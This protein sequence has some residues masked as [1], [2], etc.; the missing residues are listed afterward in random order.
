MISVVP[1]FSNLLGWL[2]YS[3]NL[4]SNGSALLS[5]QKELDDTITRL[6]VSSLYRSVNGWYMLEVT[7]KGASELSFEIIARSKKDSKIEQCFH[8]SCKGSRMTKRIAFFPGDHSL[9]VK[10]LDLHQF[11]Q[12]CDLSLVKLTKS[13]A[14]TR[15][16]SKVS[17]PSHIGLSD[18]YGV[19]GAS[20]ESY[21]GQNEYEIWKRLTEPKLWVPLVDQSS[22]ERT[23][24]VSIVM[25]V[26]NPEIAFLQSAIESVLQQTNSA[27]ELVIADDCSA[28]DVVIQ[29]LETLQDLDDR[30][31]LIR[32]SKNGNISAAS[33]SAL[34]KVSGNYVAL[35]D[36]DDQLSPNAI[37]EIIHAI[38]ISP[39]VKLIYSDEDKLN[40][41]GQRI[42][43]HFKPAFSP[44]T[45]LGQNY[46]SHITVIRTDLV[47]SVHGFREGV[48]GSQDHD[49]L[50]RILPQLDKE[51][52][53][54][55]P[56]VL[57]HWRA[58]MGS[59][60]MSA[61]Q[62]SYTWDAGVKSLTHYLAE[63][64]KQAGTVVYG[65]RPNTM[66]IKPNA[67]Q[68]KVS[69]IIPT[70][71]RLDL[72]KVCIESIVAKTDYPDYEIIV[73]D[74]NSDDEP[75]LEYMDELDRQSVI[76]LIKAPFEFNYSKI[77]NLGVKAASGELICLLN[78]DTEVVSEG[79]LNELA[80][81]AEQPEIGCV[82]A[83]LLY[84]DD[85]LQHGGV[86]VGL[87]GVA[88][89]SHLGLPAS[90]SGYFD[91]MAIVNNVSAVTAACLMVE[92]STYE[93]VAGLDESLKVAFNDIDFCLRVRE[94][95][96]R[97]IWTPHAVLYHYES[98]SR[99]YEVTPEKRARFS[100]ETK[101][102][103]ERWREKL[104]ND[105]FY[106]S[107]FDLHKESYR[108]RLQ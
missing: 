20:F 82:G 90:K 27:W 102:M 56:K 47:K 63:T 26:F 19:Y 70:R 92:K 41:S 103:K 1:S 18:L 69:I 11:N 37:N 81:W 16:Q 36:H 5:D 32:R 54:H 38:K 21:D 2:F 34:D 22:I 42:D 24:K 64:H 29:Y 78:N 77:N 33:N 4:V 55:I 73:V 45:L 89:H 106:N 88:G 99:G 53:I 57:Y 15:M 48:E 86:I 25:P 96:L 51:S 44:E 49:L 85:S 97:N 9:F 43:P 52:V 104:E 7:N 65:T 91:R 79:W 13:F 98:A 95:G 83:R 35:M 71:N 50:L 84:E 93:K 17:A 76:K 101:L 67:G 23:V 105:P 75:T 61:D 74:N 87:G 10:C 28:D 46:I 58:A 80:M 107:N 3:R 14:K 72:L 60:A 68:L 30:V 6:R 40:Q 39:N 31:V 12:R 100:S 59:T 66:R 94:M 62:K 8:F 108:L